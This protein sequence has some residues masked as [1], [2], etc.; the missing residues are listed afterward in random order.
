MLQGRD[1]L[2][3]DLS[4]YIYL[5]LQIM[6]FG[7]IIESFPDVQVDTEYSLNKMSGFA[8][9]SMADLMIDAS[10]CRYSI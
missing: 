1:K 9:K 6:T 4:Q 10:A 2:I 5:S 7:K 3:S 8:K